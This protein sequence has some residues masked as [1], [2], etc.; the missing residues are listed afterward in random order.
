MIS[1]LSLVSTRFKNNNSF[2]S[3]TIVVKKHS[4]SLGHQ[5]L[6][7]ASDFEITNS[8][9]ANCKKIRVTPYPTRSAKK[10]MFLQKGSTAENGEKREA[11]HVNAN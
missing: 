2:A 6:T 10:A 5:V 8:R 1:K 4:R 11:A 3:S 9:L 7:N